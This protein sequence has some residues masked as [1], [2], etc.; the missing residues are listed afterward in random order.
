MWGVIK[1]PLATKTIKT[2]N[3]RK[4]RQNKNKKEKRNSRKPK[5]TETTLVSSRPSPPW[6]LVCFLIRVEWE[7]CQ[8]GCGNS[9]HK[10]SVEALEGPDPL[11]VP[12]VFI[13]TKQTACW[14][15]PVYGER[16]LSFTTKSSV[17]G[18]GCNRAALD[19]KFVCRL[20][21]AL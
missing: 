13:L 9:L 1:K 15:N 2:K 20:S 21:D 11:K 18:C 7:E 17:L 19:S 8:S 14:E 4:Q 5:Q 3:K 6:F 16:G 10:I 12:P